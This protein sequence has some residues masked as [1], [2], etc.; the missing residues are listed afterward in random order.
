MVLLLLPPT[1]ESPTTATPPAAA[2]RSVNDRESH[3]LRAHGPHRFE[4]RRAVDQPPLGDTKP[5]AE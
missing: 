1:A 4:R 5:N 3:Q 2:D